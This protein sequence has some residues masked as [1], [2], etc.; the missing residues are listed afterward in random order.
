MPVVVCDGD[1]SALSRQLIRM[2][3]ASATLAVTGTV[4]DTIEGAA[5]IRKGS[6]YAMVYIPRDLERD[7]KR[8]AAPAVVLYYNNQWLLTSGLVYRAA[9][10]AVGTLSAGL[11]VRTRM[12]KGEGPAEALDRF[13]PIRT[14]LHPLF[15]PNLNYRYFLLPALF[16]GMLQAFI[17]MV[18]VRALGSELKHGTAGEWLAAAGGR[19]WVA[20]LAKLLPSGVCF[21]VLMVFMLAALTRFANVPLYGSLEVILAGS[22][23]FVLAYQSMGFALVAISANL[24][25]ANSLAGFYTGPALAFAGITYPALGM[26]PAAKVWSSC[27]PLTHYLHLLLEQALRGAPPQASMHALVVLAA[28]VVVPPVLLMPRLG[29]LLRDPDCWGRL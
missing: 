16:P 17:I 28:F 9:R 3:D 19:P 27:L 10:E 25:L 5:S 29:R 4:R 8:G 11:D 7:V 21:T 26:P 6:A 20:V 12:M 18:T 22:F 23:L 14:D 13:E 24:R 1:G 2:I 15:N